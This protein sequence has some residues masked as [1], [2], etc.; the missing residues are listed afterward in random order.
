MPRRIRLVIFDLDETLTVGKTIWELV[1]H[2]MGTWASHGDPYWEEFKRGRFGYNAFIRKDVACWKGL[3]VSRIVSAMRKVRYV[4]RLKET[5]AALKRRGVRTALVSSSLEIFAEHVSK[6]FGIDHVHA[7]A[8]EVRGGRLTGRIRLNVPGKAKGRLARGLKRRLGIKKR[9][10]L[11]IG[12]SVYDIPMFKE[13]GVNVTFD[14]A[15]LRVKGNADHVIKR[16]ALESILK[17]I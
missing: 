9:E 16:S 3:P 14:D 15:S 8:L 13:S 11:A 12:D 10:V 2:E 6:R 1:H 4:P 7:N 17:F 5:I